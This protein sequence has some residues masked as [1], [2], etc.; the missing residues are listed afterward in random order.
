V[1]AST[2][3]DVPGIARIYAHH[4]RHGTATFEIDPPGDPEIARRRSEIERGGLPY[5][6]AESEHGLVGYAYAG[7]YRPR[8]AYRFT[9]EDSIYVH[10]G[11]IGN[12]IG[13]V[14]LAELIATCEQRGLRQMVAVIGDSGNVASVRVHESFGFRHVGVLRGVGFKFGRWLDTVLMQRS[15]GEGE[16]SV[17]GEARQAVQ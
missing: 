4:V 12:G 16:N 14:L 7:I 10:P 15:L 1:R 13:R 11:H 9:V 3:A 2:E 17:P 6:V 5:L 8:I